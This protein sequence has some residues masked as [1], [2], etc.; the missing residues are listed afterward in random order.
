MAD[1]REVE[2]LREESLKLRLNTLDKGMRDITRGVQLI[3]DKQVGRP[4]PCTSESLLL[5]D[6]GSCQF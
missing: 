1:V 2:G 6:A 4:L 3:R 5:V